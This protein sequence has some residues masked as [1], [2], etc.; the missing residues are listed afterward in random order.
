MVDGIGGTDVVYIGR[1]E[2]QTFSIEGGGTYNFELTD[3]RLD[4]PYNPEWVSID[5]RG[6]NFEITG[7]LYHECV[8]APGAILL[9]SLGVGIV[10]WLRR[11]RAL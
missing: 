7:E 5:I 8:P 3:Y 6:Y 9:G 4:I 1:M 10:G 11:R 2:P